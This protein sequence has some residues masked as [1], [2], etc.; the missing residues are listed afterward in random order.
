MPHIDTRP[1]MGARY[2]S[3]APGCIQIWSVTRP[4]LD[5][6]GT[7]VDAGGMRCELVLCIEGGPAT[8]VK[9]MPLG[10]WDVVSLPRLKRTGT[11]ALAELRR[12]VMDPAC[13]S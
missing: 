9:W 4:L 7:V 2:A 8:F 13:Q 12:K 6:A 3:D 1:A 5:G 11:K 10:A